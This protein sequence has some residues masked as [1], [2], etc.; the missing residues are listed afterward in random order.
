MSHDNNSMYNMN[1]SIH[2]ILYNARYSAPCKANDDDEKPALKKRR[3][4]LS[5]VNEKNIYKKNVNDFVNYNFNNSIMKKKKC[6]PV[7]MLQGNKCISPLKNRRE[8]RNSV[9]ES[10][11]KS[12]ALRSIVNKTIKNKSNMENIQDND[13]NILNSSRF[14]YYFKKNPEKNNVDNFNEMVNMKLFLGK[15]LNETYIMSNT[16]QSDNFVGNKNRDSINTLRDTIPLYLNSES[17]ISSFNCEREIERRISKDALSNVVSPQGASSQ[18]ALSQGALSQGALSQGLSSQVAPSKFSL[19]Q[20]VPSQSVPYRKLPYKI[21]PCRVSPYKVVPSKV[22]PFRHSPYKMLP[23]KVIP[24]RGV[25]SHVMPPEEVLPSQVVSSGRVTS[26]VV[27]FKGTLSKGVPSQFLHSQNAPSKGIPSLVFPYKGLPSRAV[28][29]KGL[30]SRTTPYKGLPPRFTPYRGL[31]SRVA[32]SKV[33]AGLGIT[34]KGASPQ[35]VPSK[36]APLQTVSRNVLPR[37]VVPGKHVFPRVASYK[38]VPY[39]VLPQK[40]APEQVVPSLVAPSRDELFRDEP[41][42]HEPSRDEPPRDVASKGV[43]NC[44]HA[45][46]PHLKKIMKRCYPFLTHVRRHKKRVKHQHISNTED[47][48]DKIENNPLKRKHSTQLQKENGKYDSSDLSF[49]SKRVK[50]SKLK[51]KNSPRRHSDIPKYDD[52]NIYYCNRIK[53]IRKR[54]NHNSPLKRKCKKWLQKVKSSKASKKFY[55]DPNNPIFRTCFFNNAEDFENEGIKRKETIDPPSSSE[56]E[57]S[58]PK[59]EAEYLFSKD[60]FRDVYSKIRRM[61]EL[62]YMDELAEEDEEHYISKNQINKV[63]ENAKNKEMRYHYIDRM[64]LYR[65][66]KN[67]ID[68]VDYDKYKKKRRA[69]QKYLDIPYP[70]LRE[71]MNITSISSSDEIDDTDEFYVAEVKQLEN[72]YKKSKRSNRTDASRIDRTNEAETRLALPSR[73]TPFCDDQTTED[74]TSIET[75]EKLMVLMDKLKK[76]KDSFFDGILDT[77]DFSKLL[78]PAFSLN[79]SFILSHQMFNVQFAAQ[80]GPVVYLLK[81]EDENYV[82]RAIEVSR[83]FE[84]KVKSILENQKLDT[85]SK[86][87]NECCDCTSVEKYPYLRELDVKYYLRIPM[88]TGWN[89]FAYLNNHNNVLFFRKRKDA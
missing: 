13:R 44:M 82:Y 34:S 23:Y 7:H 67:V 20:F 78:D 22:A 15:N 50:T 18:G 30:P 39:K 66:A 70:N 26:Q 65:H 77:P 63:I 54:I 27:P 52:G 88:S 53:R 55:V 56:V 69:E 62:N 5:Y 48:S 83:Q 85:Q 24:Y 58:M 6:S 10:I 45:K 29:Y 33:V 59:N 12:V 84:E 17:T 19:S 73:T 75:R 46:L 3:C 61:G 43:K 80:L 68:D 28:P 81:T 2:K 72:Y 32:A 11:K 76:E 36:D 87:R 41:S 38:L 74:V 86:E 21:I 47:I 42:R 31:P 64:F 71:I 37:K 16:T 57:E 89:H 4:T 14:D 8:L 1:L 25:P 40:I 79:E 49:L 35:V 60:F 9:D 51:C